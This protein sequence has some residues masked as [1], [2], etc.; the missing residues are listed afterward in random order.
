MMLTWRLLAT[1]QRLQKILPACY[2]IGLL[3]IQVYICRRVFFLEYTGQ[4]HSRHF[5]RAGVQCGVR[6]GVLFRAGRSF[7]AGV[8]C[9]PATWLE[10]HRRDG[11]FAHVA[12]GADLSGREV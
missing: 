11:L 10:F 12:D 4:M 5:R 7:S 1:R 6:T 3:W 2:I 9:Y 8:A